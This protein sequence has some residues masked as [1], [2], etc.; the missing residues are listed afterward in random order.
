VAEERLDIFDIDMV[1]Q[2]QRGE[3]MAQH[4]SSRSMPEKLFFKYRN[5]TVGYLLIIFQFYFN[6]LI[7]NKYIYI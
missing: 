6:L 2:K 4:I 5:Y 7:T 3:S 1:L